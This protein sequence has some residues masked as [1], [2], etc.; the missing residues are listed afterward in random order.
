MNSLLSR[1]PYSDELA[2]GDVDDN[3]DLIDINDEE[4]TTVDENG[5][6]LLTE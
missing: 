3:K 5:Y 4:E 1:N 2:N 6:I